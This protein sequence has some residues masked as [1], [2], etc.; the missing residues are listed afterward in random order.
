M[1]N[2]RDY[3]EVPEEFMDQLASTLMNDPVQL[4]SG[5]FV[6]RETIKHELARGRANPFTRQPI[7]EADLIEGALLAGA[8]GIMHAPFSAGAEGA[9]PGVQGE[10]QVRQAAPAAGGE[11]GQHAGDGGG[12]EEGCA[13]VSRRSGSRDARVQG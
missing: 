10:A 12:G 4:P 5:Q 6:D 7:T 1:E 9:H 13:E 3:G 2:E 11:P 8:L